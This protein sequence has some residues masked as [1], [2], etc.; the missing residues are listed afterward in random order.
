LRP[1]C[2]YRHGYGS[3]GLGSSLNSKKYKQASEQQKALANSKKT[4]PNGKKHLLTAQNTCEQQET[5]VNGQKHQ[6]TAKKQL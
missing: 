6:L 5:P 4:L 3:F 2:W 1:C